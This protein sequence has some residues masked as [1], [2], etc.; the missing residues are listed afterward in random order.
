[1]ITTN[2]PCPNCKT[3]KE[4]RWIDR[5]LRTIGYFYGYSCDNCGHKISMLM[6]K[7]AY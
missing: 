1:M 5:N 2:Q 7:G 6:N 4:M 3:K